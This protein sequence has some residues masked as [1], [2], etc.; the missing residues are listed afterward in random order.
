MLNPPEEAGGPVEA[1]RGERVRQLLEEAKRLLALSADRAKAASRAS[2]IDGR[3]R[4]LRSTRQ[5]RQ[6]R[7]GR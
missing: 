4:A 5:G 7:P 1:A 2:E 6:G 3:L